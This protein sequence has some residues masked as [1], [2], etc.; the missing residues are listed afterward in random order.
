MLTDSE[1]KKAYEAIDHAR[2]LRERLRRRV[3]R[4][5][6]ERNREID[7]ALA[8][9]KRAMRPVRSEI[10]RTQYWPPNHYRMGLLY[11]SADL[12]KERRKLW[13][14]RRP[15][16]RTDLS[17]ANREAARIRIQKELAENQRVAARTV[18]TE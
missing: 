4:G 1:R 5:S 13:K 9:I 8:K 18:I 12:I 15:P 11:L 10:H 3:R 14:L 2:T 16:K 7:L 6:P 17:A